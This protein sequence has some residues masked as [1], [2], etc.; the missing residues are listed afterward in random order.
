MSV[1][2]PRLGKTGAGQ[3]VR[4]GF[5]V[6]VAVMLTVLV[7]AGAARASDPVKG[8]IKILTQDG[9]TRLVL[10][11]AEPVTAKIQLNW[12]IMVI[13]FKKPVSIPVDRLDLKAPK[14]ISAERLDQERSASRFALKKK[15]NITKKPGR[16]TR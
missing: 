4:R 12:P 10:K 11:L 1:S 9:Y 5:H 6:A 16:E 3:A 8:D 2:P 15:V 14:M 7:S 13:A